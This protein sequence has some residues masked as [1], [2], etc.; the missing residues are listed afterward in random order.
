MKKNIELEFHD[1]DMMVD[2]MRQY[3]L[4][5]GYTLKPE[6]DTSRSM[7][8]FIDAINHN[9]FLMSTD[10]FEK[11]KESYLEK[12]NAEEELTQGEK[13]NLIERAFTTDEGKEA[14]ILC[15]VNR[16]LDMAKTEDGQ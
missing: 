14:F 6:D 1:L 15:T 9:W 2:W 16:Y 10:S 5:T 13:I 8:G 12:G 11:W 7:F 4:E 3:A